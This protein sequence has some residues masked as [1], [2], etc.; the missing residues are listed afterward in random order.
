M[1]NG[2]FVCLLAGCRVPVVLRRVETHYILLGSCLVIGLM[3][4]EAHEA[5]EKGKL[6]WQEFEIH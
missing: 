3:E 4:G 6:W 2:D 1:M 5:A